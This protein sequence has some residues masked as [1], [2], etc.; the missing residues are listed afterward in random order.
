MFLVL[1]ALS[2]LAVFGSTVLAIA[3]VYGFFWVLVKISDWLGE[4][5]SMTYDQKI[6]LQVLLLMSLIVSF[7]MTLRL[8]EVGGVK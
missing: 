3:A 5:G 8:Y 4:W 6:A 1:W 2:F 7:V